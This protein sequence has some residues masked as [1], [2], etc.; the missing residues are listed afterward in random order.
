MSAVKTARSVWHNP[1]PQR[2]QNVQQEVLLR[3]VQ[4]I[5]WPSIIWSYDFTKLRWYG[6]FP[7]EVMFW[8]PRKHKQSKDAYLSIW[9]SQRARRP[10]IEDVGMLLFIGIVP[11]LLSSA[12]PA[13]YWHMSPAWPSPG[14]IISTKSSAGGYRFYLFSYSTFSPLVVYLQ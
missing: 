8:L 3:H 4:Y 13:P 12:S 9:Y 2:N 10:S 6:W 11:A 5:S 14:H 7:A 1:G